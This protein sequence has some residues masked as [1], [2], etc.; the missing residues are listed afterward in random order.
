MLEINSQTCSGSARM[1]E[2]IVLAGPARWNPLPGEESGPALQE[3]HVCFSRT[4]QH[5][6]LFASLSDSIF[7]GSHK[8]MYL[9]FH[10]NMT[11]CTGMHSPS[12]R[13]FCQ[14]I[15]VSAVQKSVEK[16][17]GHHPFSVHQVTGGSRQSTYHTV[18]HCGLR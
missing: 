18:F 1:L 10:P 4:Q 14:L 7:F 3:S 6:S 13:L 9:A 12:I 17:R 5:F 8:F 2:K 16:F 15:T 11:L